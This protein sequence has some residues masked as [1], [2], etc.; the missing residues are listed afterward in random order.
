MAERHGS[1]ERDGSTLWRTQN[2]LASPSAIDPI[3]DRSGIGKGDVVIDIGAGAGMVTAAIVARGA[4]V[5][6]VERDRVLCGALRRRFAM[7]DEVTV[8]CRDFLGMSLP[9]TSY[10]VFASPPFDVITAIVTKLTRAKRP[11]DDVLLTV[12][13]EAAARYA[14][15]PSETLYALLLKPWF[16]PSVIHRF[17]PDDFR[18][19]P[20]VDVVMLRLRKRGPPLVRS[21][22][23]HLY[24]DFV[25]ACFT[26][27][28]PTLGAALARVL[29]PRSATILLRQVSLDPARPPSSVP[30]SEWLKLFRAF[31]RSPV[32]VRCRVAGAERH[33]GAQQAHVRKRHRTRVPRDDLLARAE[34]RRRRSLTKA[35]PSRRLAYVLTTSPGK[36]PDLDQ[37]G[38]RDRFR[39]PRRESALLATRSGTALSETSS[40]SARVAWRRCRSPTH[41][42]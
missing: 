5:L 39:G 38:E 3:L 32:Q 10:K 26:A 2:F 16:A 14:G 22:E 15:H 25:T 12:Q 34:V 40:I 9:S 18:P 21:S 17:H 23:G 42:W 41:L 33:L 35:A 24:R 13:R 19:R 30:F 29:G 31:A 4:R 6:A 11:P 7:T 20:G 28:R 27:W 1:A 37:R 36:S 8:E